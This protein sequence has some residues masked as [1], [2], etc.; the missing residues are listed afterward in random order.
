MTDLW[1]EIQAAIYYGGAV[2]A[3][4][5]L[6]T[7]TTDLVVV[8]LMD[9]SPEGRFPALIGA[10]GWVRRRD[11]ATRSAPYCQWTRGAAPR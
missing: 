3:E 11:F 4:I 7:S 10:P 8:C 9:G 5:Y 6:P 1:Q 2:A